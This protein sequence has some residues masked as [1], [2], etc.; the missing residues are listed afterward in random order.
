MLNPLI[1][2]DVTTLALRIHHEIERSLIGLR[3]LTEMT[4]KMAIPGDISDAVEASL[5]EVRDYLTSAK[6]GMEMALFDGE[7]VTDQD[8]LL[9]EFFVE[10][11]EKGE[12]GYRETEWF[13]CSAS[14]IDHAIEQALSAYPEAT[15][16]SVVLNL[17]PE[18]E[19][20]AET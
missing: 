3:T 8:A 9:C 19:H 11:L 12:V 1:N 10:Y 20:A 6:D 14:S 18:V 16:L 17:A 4:G 7:P 15:I 2:T 5:G 13:R